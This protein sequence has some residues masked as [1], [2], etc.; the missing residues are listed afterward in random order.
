MLNAVNLNL[1]AFDV[2]LRD[3]AARRPGVHAVR[4]HDRRRRGRA[5]PGHRAARLPQPRD[6][7]RRR[8][9]PSCGEPR[10]D[11]DRARTDDEPAA[12]VA[13]TPVCVALAAPFV[14]AVV[15]LLRRPTLAAA[16]RCRS[17]SPAR[18]VALVAALGR[19]PRRAIAAGA[20]GARDVGRACDRPDRRAR[21]SRVGTC[22][23]TGSPR[24]SSRSWSRV[25]ALAVQVYS[26]AYLQGRPALLLVR[27]LRLAVHRGDAARRLRR[28]P[29]RAAVGW[30]VM[31]V[32]SY[33]LIGHHWEQPK[34]R[35]AA[36]SRRSWSP[37]SATSASC[38]ASSCSASA[39]RHRSDIADVLAHVRRP[40]RSTTVTAA[41]LL[42]L[43]GVVGKSRA[44]PAA[45]LAARRDGRPDA[46]QRAD[47]RGHDGRRRHLR[48]RPALPG[49]PRRAG[50]AG[51]AGGH[52]LRSP[53]WAPRWP[54]SPRTTSSGC[55]PTRRSASSPTCSAALA[56][57]SAHGG[58][59]PPAHPRRVQGA[60][61]P[62]R[63]LGHPRRRHQ[64]D[65]ATWAGCAGPCRSRSRR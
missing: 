63:R 52:R 58:D 9:R 59:L 39:A 46:D 23:S 12:A 60:A 7:R 13:V 51:R 47:P 4:H 42:L 28:R 41:T 19:S 33:F 65:A 31:G 44:V 50:D 54:R 17:R 21:R 56:V 26:V 16:R 1:V 61:V 49:V 40:C 11:R 6:R 64:P 20:D 10:P 48:R 32:C 24:W 37:G 15:G 34:A 53:C 43:C 3:R 2:W 29:V 30:E 25:V 57:G 27:R 5:R 22:A 14:A 62:R 18:R 8:A 38:S 55:S 36:P 35:G 45:H